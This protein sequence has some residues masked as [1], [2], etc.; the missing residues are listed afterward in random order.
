MDANAST[1]KLEA[2]LFMT[3]AARKHL[4]GTLPFRWGAHALSRALFRTPAEHFRALVGQT[5]WWFE[6]S[7]PTDEGVRWDTRGR[8]YSPQNQSRCG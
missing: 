3:P 7:Q 5:V 4:A 6:N 1:C 8:V 2:F